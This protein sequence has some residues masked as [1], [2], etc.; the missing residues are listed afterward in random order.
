MLEHFKD[1]MAEVQNFECTS[2]DWVVVIAQ[3]HL[4]STCACS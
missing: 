2:V 1:S 4:A 3:L